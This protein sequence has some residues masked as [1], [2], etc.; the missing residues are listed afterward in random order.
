MICFSSEGI[1]VSHNGEIKE[2]HGPYGY[3]C[4]GLV[5]LWNN[6]N[7][8]LNIDKIILVKVDLKLRCP[9]TAGLY[10]DMFQKPFS[11]VYEKNG[12][13]FYRGLPIINYK[14]LN[15]PK[16]MVGIKEIQN[17]EHRLSWEEYYEES[18][19][20][21][22]EFGFL[23]LS[24]ETDAEGNKKYKYTSIWDNID[25]LI[26]LN[27]Q[28]LEDETMGNDGCEAEITVSKETDEKLA[29]RGLDNM[30]YDEAI[31]SLIESCQNLKDGIE[32]YEKRAN[33]LTVKNKKLK[34]AIIG[35]AT[36]IGLQILLLVKKNE[37][38][39]N[40]WFIA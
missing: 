17:S 25:M 13:F 33:E 11:D 15:I 37:Y 12:I 4:L 29:E 1:S 38:I 18:C 19:K 31:E 22:K 35:C 30:T 36:I 10:Y 34:L 7:K 28:E 2:S 23:N 3:L 21:S 40:Y 6:E 24:V 8:C 14:Q 16:K 32:F 9:I 20:R 39:L 5:Y 26:A 27:A